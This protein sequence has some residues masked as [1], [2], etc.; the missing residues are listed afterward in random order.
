MG[1]KST[2]AV[3]IERLQQAMGHID[4]AAELYD[5]AMEVYLPQFDHMEVCF[6]QV[7]QMLQLARDVMEQSF[8]GI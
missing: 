7:M 2:R 3:N 6:Q 8:E 1:K 5:L 4:K